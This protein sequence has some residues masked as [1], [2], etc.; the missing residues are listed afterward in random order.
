MTELELDIPAHDDDDEEDAPAF[1]DLDEVPDELLDP[2]PEPDEEG[3]DSLNDPDRGPFGQELEQK[4]LGAMRSHGPRAR[5]RIIPLRRT[6][7]RGMKGKDVVA[8]KRALAHAGLL[9]WKAKRTIVAG[10][11]WQEAVRRFQRHNKLGADGVYGKATHRK[12]VR[13]GHFDKWGAHLMAE[14][15]RPQPAGG[16]GM[17]DRIEAYAL[18]AYHNRNRLWYLQRRPMRLAG[19]YELPSWEDCSEFAT[20][21]YKAGGAP[22]PNG[23]NYSGL[24]YTGT[25]SQHGRSGVPRSAALHFYG[26]GFPYTHV[27]IGAG[28]SNCF[29]MGSDRGPLLVPVRYRPDYAQTRVYL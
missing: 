17:I 8:T 16:Q 20:R 4:E 21:C 5:A 7:H 2:A 25:L 23:L 13:L 24:G 12:L 19:L 6:L 15:P 14:A 10:P 26:G 18:W 29:S 11:K 28:S 3:D 27:T 22:D 9:P 1:I